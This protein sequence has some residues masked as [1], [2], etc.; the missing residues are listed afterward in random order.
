MKLVNL[1]IPQ[2]LKKG[3]LGEKYYFVYANFDSPDGWSIEEA[4]SDLDDHN[5]FT[6]G[7][8]FATK[9]EC[10]YFISQLKKLTL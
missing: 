5:R 2:P 6:G 4:Y 10:E 7:R 8:C 3:I 1:Q 9:E